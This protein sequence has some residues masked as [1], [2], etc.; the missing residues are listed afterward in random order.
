[1][2]KDV[3]LEVEVVQ[4]E[5][6]IGFDLVNSN[7]DPIIYVAGD[8]SL[9]DLTFTVT[10]NTG[11]DLSLTA[12]DS[13]FHIA[14]GPNL[15]VDQENIQVNDLAEWDSN[16]V[17][18]RFSYIEIKPSSDITFGDGQNL[19]FTL[20][21]ITSSGTSGDNDNVTIAYYS[22]GGFED[23]SYQLPFS[24]ADPPS[25]EK[26]DLNLIHQFI[27]SN[28][29]YLTKDSANP[30]SNELVFSLS[31]PSKTGPLIP[32][33]VS[34][35]DNT[36]KFTISFVYGASPAYG[37]LTTTQNASDININIDKSYGN[38]WQIN[39]RAGGSTP[40]WELSPNPD[41]HEI[42]GTG[43][44]ASIDLDITDIVTELEA[45]TTLMYIQNS[46]IPGYNDGCYA[47]Q[48][49][50]KLPTPGILSFFVLDPVID[51][52]DSTALSWQT[53]G[54]K[55]VT[56]QYQDEH[57]DEITLNSE[58]REIDKGD[59]DKTEFIVKPTHDT[60][61][62]L[63]AYDDNG[64]QRDQKQ[65]SI[66]VTLPEVQ[67]D[68]WATPD[69]V[70]DFSN[71]RKVTLSWKIKNGE[72]LDDLILDNNI[73]NVE[74]KTSYEV[75]VH[76][77]TRFTIRATNKQGVQSQASVIVSY[78]EVIE[79]DD[80]RPYCSIALAPDYSRLYLGCKDLDIDLDIDSQSYV[81]V[82][83]S[84]E[85]KVEIRTGFWPQF[86]VITSD[87]SKG[88]VI[89]LQTESYISVIPGQPDKNCNSL[90]TIK[91]NS[92]PS[93]LVLSHDNNRL[94]ASMT[95]DNVVSVIDTTQ[96]SY[97]SIKQVKVGDE[98]GP[99][100]ISPDGNRLYV[101]NNGNG[102]VSVINT[103]QESYPII[104]TIQV[105]EN[106]CCMSLAINSDG[107]R[108]FVGNSKYKNITVISICQDLWQIIKTIS[109]ELFPYKIIASLDNRR[110]L[111][112]GCRDANY[113]PPGG[114]L[115][116][117]Y[118]N[119]DSYSPI[120]NIDPKNNSVW[121]WQMALGANDYKLFITGCSSLHIIDRVPVNND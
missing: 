85:N 100:V 88:Y 53:Y 10:N 83:D 42:L 99:M 95:S 81:M 108:L 48:I 84:V 5:Q 73:G 102:T 121:G 98:P 80:G 19:Q 7:G 4:E 41:N 8:S 86:I 68:F 56:L 1:M 120:E 40:Y 90:S 45:G 107:T 61:Y 66:G 57:Y 63:T 13:S 25:T 21:N 70:S 72:Y 39:K 119:Q 12:S 104:E 71:K 67:I 20:T 54:V 96:E 59:N 32:D 55:S 15:C 33:D 24:L 79:Q 23:G 52:E 106:D 92:E 44:N 69:T 82:I 28:I 94:F 113:D 34:W 47:L 101:A 117:V 103:T 50:K 30:I 36:P 75:T 26:K 93:C 62:T 46:N 22:I 18:G 43:Q 27:S 2:K 17:S 60:T 38:D 14:F 87:G 37:A 35:G 64:I 29:V 49:E 114:R 9:N 105:Y 77:P 109:L 118:S 89:F 110:I 11:N 78:Y 6:G 74:G 65:V 16:Y 51:E 116:I 3:K 31:N 91:V 97:P 76:K 58:K 112:F 115:S 111:V